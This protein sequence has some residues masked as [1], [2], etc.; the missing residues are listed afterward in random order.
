MKELLWIFCSVWL[1]GHKDGLVMQPPLGPH[2]CHLPCA[3][4]CRVEAALLWTTQVLM[5]GNAGNSGSGPGD[6]DR[7]SSIC[8]FA[9]HPRELTSTP[10]LTSHSL[11]SGHSTSLS[12]WSVLSWAVLHSLLLL[13]SGPHSSPERWPGQWTMIHIVQVG[14]R[15]SG[16]FLLFPKVTV[17]T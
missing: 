16:R 8:Y 9:S 3:Q 13:I 7:E 14:R 6:L 15:S 5:L 11:P 1:S 12:L 10:A 2:V 4:R 17:N